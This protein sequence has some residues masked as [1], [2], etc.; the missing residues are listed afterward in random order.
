VLI[1]WRLGTRDGSGRDEPARPV[2]GLGC[3]MER[4]PLSW[5]DRLGDARMAVMWQFGGPDVDCATTEACKKWGGLNFE[6]FFLWL[7]D[8]MVMWLVRRIPVQ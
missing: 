8:G 4:L 3:R 5:D 6:G 1:A 2:I 7:C